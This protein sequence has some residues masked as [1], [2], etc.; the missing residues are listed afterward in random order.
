M[1]A[2]N[3]TDEQFARRHGYVVRRDRNG[4]YV[5]GPREKARALVNGRFETF[6]TERMAWE[7]A[8]ERIDAAKRAARRPRTAAARAC[9]CERPRNDDHA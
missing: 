3:E 6:D 2:I 4:W 9:G 8:A 1:R 7:A 5:I